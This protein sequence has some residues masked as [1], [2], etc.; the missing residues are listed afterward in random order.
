MTLI[1]LV[2]VII[3][4]GIIA[5]VA[6]PRLADVSGSAKVSSAEGSI[7]AFKSALTITQA[8]HTAADP[9][10]TSILPNLDG[11]VS[12]TGKVTADFDGDS[13]DDLTITGYDAAC[14]DGTTAGGS[15]LAAGNE[16][17]KGAWKAY[18]NVVT[19]GDTTCVNL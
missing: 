1:E 7:G 6:A 2:I 19:G 9:A 3:V 13:T 5:A 18:L 8:L 16:G 14:T 15:A 17:T 4:L 11:F 10:W 12:S